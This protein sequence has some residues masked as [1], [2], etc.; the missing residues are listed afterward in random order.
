M[1]A[2]DTG[3]VYCAH[4]YCFAIIIGKAGDLCDDCR[5]EDEGHDYEDCSGCDN[6]A[7]GA[8]R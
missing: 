7:E 5:A 1:S 2:T 6:D 4:Q 3:Y 8:S